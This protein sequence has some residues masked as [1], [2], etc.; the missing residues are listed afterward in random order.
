MERKECDERKEGCGKNE[1]E[2]DTEKDMK[3]REHKE[4]KN[5][6]QWHWWLI[7]DSTGSD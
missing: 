4:W 1:M 6:R 7:P 2:R 3:K 5:E